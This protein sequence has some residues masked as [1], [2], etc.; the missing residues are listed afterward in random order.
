MTGTAPSGPL[1]R[2]VEEA[3]AG[4]ETLGFRKSDVL[5]AVETFAVENPEA[6]TDT[7]IR[8]ILRNKK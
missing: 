3:L 7:I 4:L 5:K 6:K 1:D 8:H 2:R